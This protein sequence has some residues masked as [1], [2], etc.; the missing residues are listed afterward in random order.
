MKSRDIGWTRV[1]CCSKFTNRFLSIDI[2]IRLSYRD[3]SGVLP[4]WP[5]GHSHWFRGNNIRN[6][7]I[8]QKVSDRK[9]GKLV[10]NGGLLV[11]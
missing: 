3:S 4:N 10:N 8:H 1:K 11:I 7:Y 6:T 2:C 5:G 9:N